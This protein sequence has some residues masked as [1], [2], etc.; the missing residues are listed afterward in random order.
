MFR[1]SLTKTKKLSEKTK[2]KE[3][4]AKNT[5]TRETFQQDYSARV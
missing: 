1:N 2:Y 5:E 3:Q 4:K